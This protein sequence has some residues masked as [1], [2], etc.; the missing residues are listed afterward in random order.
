MKFE[1]TNFD[2]KNRYIQ[3]QNL[4][5]QIQKKTEITNSIIY[6]IKLLKQKDYFLIRYLGFKIVRT[7]FKKALYFGCYLQIYKY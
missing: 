4:L 3:L 6:G 5:Q 7:D 2:I 1:R